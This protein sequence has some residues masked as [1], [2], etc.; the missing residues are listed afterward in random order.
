MVIY[1]QKHGK[2]CTN[3]KQQ[4]IEKEIEK[5]S[6][7]YVNT[8]TE[9]QNSMDEINAS[10]ETSWMD[11]IIGVSVLG[12]IIIATVCFCLGRRCFPRT[13]SNQYEEPRI[14]Q[15]IVKEM[16]TPTVSCVDEIVA[17]TQFT[18]FEDHIYEEISN[19]E[20]PYDHLNFNSRQPIPIPTNNTYHNF[21]LLDR[22]STNNKKSHP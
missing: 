9:G 18:S 1:N 17:S 15:E 5:A 10:K 3:E 2:S 16:E 7:D 21:L 13:T 20:S 11:I 12:G 19:L 22:K 8:S 4:T 6:S 14:T